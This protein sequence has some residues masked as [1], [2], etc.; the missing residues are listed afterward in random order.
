MALRTVYVTPTGTSTPTDPTSRGD[1]YDL[2]SSAEVGERGDLTAGGLDRQLEIVLEDGTYTETA[3][4]DWLAANW[5]TDATHDIVVKGDTPHGALVRITTN[6]FAPV[7]RTEFGPHITFTGFISDHQGTSASSG[8]RGIDIRNG[9]RAL[10]EKMILRGGYGARLDG[11]S[12]G[13]AVCKNSVLIGDIGGVDHGSYST[14]LH[15]TCISVGNAGGIDVNSSTSTVAE[16]CYARSA[17]GTDL[18]ETGGTLVTQTNIHT[19]DTSG[20][21]PSVAYN[22][23]NFTNVTAGSEDLSLPTG[24]AL[25]GAASASTETEDILGNA[26]TDPEDVGAYENIPTGAHT[27]QVPTGPWR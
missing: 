20:D 15:C 12:A 1:G 3:V 18:D 11:R 9:D 10:V 21:T 13:Q 16:H 8:H 5:T 17:N 24:S 19:A 4:V 25:I 23:S 27:I 7:I 22:T 26:R 2:L 14:L 6:T